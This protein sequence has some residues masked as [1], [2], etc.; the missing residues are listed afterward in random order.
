MNDVQAQTPLRASAIIALCLFAAGL[1]WG[2]ST[3][4]RAAG[5]DFSAPAGLD[6]AGLDSGGLYQ[7]G[8]YHGNLLDREPVIQIA[9]SAETRG[10][11]FPCGT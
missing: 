10:E 9:Y 11:I 8:V 5:R 7:E 1:C 6:P 4:A 2:L 3:P